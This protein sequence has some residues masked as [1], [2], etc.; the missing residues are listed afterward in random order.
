MVGTEEL[1]KPETE[2]KRFI[3][4]RASLC[5]ACQAD[6]KYGCF[7]SA[8]MINYIIKGLFFHKNVNL[9]LTC[10]KEQ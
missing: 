6:K 4:S 10:L 9:N 5:C 2:T 1:V 7:P 8:N 3:K